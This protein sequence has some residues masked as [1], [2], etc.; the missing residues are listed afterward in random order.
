MEQRLLFP[1]RR[2]PDVGL[3]RLHGHERVGL[4]L[5]GG[6][7]RHGLDRLEELGLRGESSSLP[8]A[9]RRGVQS[10]HHLP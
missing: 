4:R 2:S 7:T 6:H 1:S 9:E 10:D 3:K 8:R 5:H